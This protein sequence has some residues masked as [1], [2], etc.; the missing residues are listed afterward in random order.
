MILTAATYI[1][2]TEVRA[3]HIIGAVFVF[4]LRLST[5]DI[6]KNTQDK[7]K[8][9]H[10]RTPAGHISKKSGRITPGSKAYVLLTHVCTHLLVKHA[11]RSTFKQS[12]GR[13]VGRFI[14]HIE[15]I[16]FRHV[17][18]S[19]VP[20]IRNTRGETAEER[21]TAAGGPRLTGVGVSHARQHR[22]SAVHGLVLPEGLRRDV[23]A[24]V[25]RVEWLAAGLDVVPSDSLKRR[26]HLHQGIRVPTAAH[27]HIAS[28][29]STSIGE[30]RRCNTAERK[31][32][33]EKDMETR[34]R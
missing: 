33:P 10:Q 8:Q 3:V 20:S 7:N 28:S 21:S 12:E 5:F 9:P 34:D 13:W 1:Q 25:Q 19:R 24:Q 2:N 18:Y 4:V 26:L 16:M 27:M 32:K 14:F 15:C 17:S 30:E 22:H 11:R 29:T 6:I 23:L 31:G